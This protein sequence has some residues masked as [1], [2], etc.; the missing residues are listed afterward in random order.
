MILACLILSPLSD[1]V[2]PASLYIVPLCGSVYVCHDIG[3]CR[4][5]SVVPTNIN[6]FKLVPGRSQ[7]TRDTKHKLGPETPSSR[8][9]HSTTLIALARH[10]VAIDPP[11]DIPPP[12]DLA[13]P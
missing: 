10:F 1:R 12:L 13:Q 4:S 5:S 6:K 7:P 9:M 11:C 2:R 8:Q 3:R